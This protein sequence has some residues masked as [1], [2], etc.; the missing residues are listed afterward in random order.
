MEVGIVC[1]LKKK[2]LKYINTVMWMHVDISMH[3]SVMSTY[4]AVMPQIT[5]SAIFISRKS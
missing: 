4:S 2:R 1:I 5:T 3:D